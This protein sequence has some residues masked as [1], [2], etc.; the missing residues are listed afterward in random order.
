MPRSSPIVTWLLYTWY[1]MINQT[2]SIRWLLLLGAAAAVLLGAMSFLQVSSA[3]SSDRRITGYCA[4]TVVR[5]YLAAIERAAPVR[6]LPA[7]GHL[8]FLPRGVSVNVIGNGVEVKRATIGFAFSDNAS[9]HPRHLN[10]SIKAT[11]NR[12]TASGRVSEVL[13]ERSQFV[14]SR[15]I[16]S[17]SPNKQRFAVPPAPAYYRVDIEFQRR[18]GKALGRYSQYFRVMR[19]R[20]EVK[21]EPSTEVVLPGQKLDVRLTNLG[22]EPIQASREFLV[23]GYKQGTWMLVDTIFVG[24]KPFHGKEFVY[25]GETGPCVS[26]VLPDEVDFSRYTFRDKV[27]R[28]LKHGATQTMSASVRVAGAG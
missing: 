23:E 9:S 15:Q 14:G 27:T 18:S 16:E 5:N 2:S 3:T 24:N 26:Y 12:V 28:Y 21:V 8:P 10:M 1:L 25:G 13:K 7:S 11:L 19:P 17:D 4:P 22:T 6:Q 20:F